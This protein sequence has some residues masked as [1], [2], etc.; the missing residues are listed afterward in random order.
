[1]DATERSRFLQQALLDW[2]AVHRRPLP[3]RE[4]YNPYSTWIAE[5]MMQQTQMDRGVMYYQRW[6]E[7][8][9]DVA[10]VAAASEEDVLKAWEGLGYYRRARNIQTAAKAIMTRYKGRFPSSPDALSALPGIG[11]Y[12]AG[13]IAST[14]FNRPVPCVDGNV[15]RV[16]SRVFDIDSPVRAEPAKSRIR[17][18]ATG[19]IPTG[20][21]R[22][23]N[24]ALME[25]GALVCRK[26]PLCEVC[27]LRQVCE[28][29]RLGLA[30]E[31]PVPGR[32]A[33]ITFLEAVT[34]VLLHEGRLFVQRRPDAGVWAG[35]WEFP[36]GRLKPDETPEE[37][38][39]RTWKEDTAFDVEAAEKITV[40]HHSYTTCR[41]TLHCFTAR[42]CSPQPSCP[43][44][45]AL[46]NA[47]EYRW[48]EPDEAARLTLPAPLRKLMNLLTTRIPTRSTRDEIAPQQRKQ[49]QP[50]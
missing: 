7:R 29:L 35:L 45:P 32:K 20:R 21:A 31:R 28:S 50:H 49:Q 4:H 46:H 34:G 22:D 13:A 11:P 37:A 39:R 26:K 14:A 24:Q 18:L 38:L 10:S 1:M 16:L 44:P 25:L 2:F 19:L 48:I 36:G 15:E 5:V 42:F 33:N 43:A 3:W 47:S 30:E 8:F 6:M 17:D 12:T 23:F 40:L 9:P 41:I 27:P